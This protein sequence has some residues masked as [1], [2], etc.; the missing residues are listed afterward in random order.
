MVLGTVASASASARFL[1][2]ST[3]SRQLMPGSLFVAL[4]GPHHDG[5][6]HLAAVAAAGATGAVVEQRRALGLPQLVVADTR[7]ALG[8]L[9]HYWRRRWPLKLIAVTGS[10]GK[11]TVKEMIAQVTAQLGPTLVTQ[12]NQNNEI[13]VPLTIL[14]GRPFHQFAVVEM[15]MSA[16]GE[17]TRLSAIG[18]PDIAV[19]T[20][21]GPAHL[22]HFR[23][24]A[25]VARAKGEVLTGLNSGGI[26]IINGDDPGAEGWRELAGPRQV[27]DFALDNPQAAIRGRWRPVETGG[28]LEVSGEYGEWRVGIPLLGRHN[29]ANALAAIAV[30]YALGVPVEGLQAAMARCQPVAGRLQ[31]LKTPGGAR[32]ID[33]S[34]NANPVSLAAAIAVLAEQQGRRLLVLGDMAELGPDSQEFHREAG[35]AAR[36]AGIDQLITVGTDSRYASEAFG[37]GAQ[38][39]SDQAALL[40]RLVSLGAGDVLLVKGSRTAAMDQVVAALMQSNSHQVA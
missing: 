21:A 16:A 24:V 22:E 25:A 12:G 10:N 3:D 9:A 18:R 28:E 37:H 29:G 11:T 33:D 30:G 20:N 13:G 35:L 14:R 4:R 32:L 38:H 1:Q 6:D 5:H 39:C 15:G 31:P 36:Q 27:I 2:V 19:I 40:Q 17:L 26:A 7:V 8:R 23:D 34:Y